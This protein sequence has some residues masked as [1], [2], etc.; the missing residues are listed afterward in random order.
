MGLT[1]PLHVGGI[2]CRGHG[3]SEYRILLVQMLI[4]SMLFASDCWEDP[5]P[6]CKLCGACRLFELKGRF[7]LHRDG[8]Q[9]GIVLRLGLE[10]FVIKRRR[11]PGPSSAIKKIFGISH[12]RVCILTP[13]RRGVDARSIDLCSILVDHGQS[14][15]P[16][17]LPAQSSNHSGRACMRAYSTFDR[18]AN[19]PKKLEDA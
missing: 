2:L 18:H 3:G 12:K 14:W 11:D 15:P 10:A 13:V 19:L 7:L 8:W 4:G 16:Q 9:G 17:I 6:R 5:F 1:H